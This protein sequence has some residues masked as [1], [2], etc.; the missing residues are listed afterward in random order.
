MHHQPRIS[1]LLAIASTQR[2]IVFAPLC[3]HLSALRLLGALRPFWGDLR[4][5]VRSPLNL[6]IHQNQD[7]QTSI[8]QLDALG[9]LHLALIE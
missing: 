3:L 9:H 2:I 6:S 7:E 1:G 8:L 4:V 5:M